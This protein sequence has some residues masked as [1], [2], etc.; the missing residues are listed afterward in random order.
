MGQDHEFLLVSYDE[1]E[2]MGYDGYSPPTD[3]LSNI[4][5]IHD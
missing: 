2:E 1:Y 3:D 5:L 4:A